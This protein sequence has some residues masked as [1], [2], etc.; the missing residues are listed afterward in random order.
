MIN[1]TNN[2]IRS[3]SASAKKLMGAFLL[4]LLFFGA[5]S[6]EGP[7]IISNYEHA[8]SPA[9]GKLMVEIINLN[10]FKDNE[11]KS[12]YTDGYTLTGMWIRPKLLYYPDEKFRL[13]LGGQVLAYNGRQDYKLYPWFSAV[14]MPTKNIA[15]RMGNLDQDLNHG[16]AEPVMDSEYILKDK[17]EAGFQAKFNFSRWNADF[18]IDWQ[19]MIFKGDPYKERFVFGTAGAVT[20]FQNEKRKL[21]MPIVFNGLHEGGEIDAAPG[22]AQTHIVVS[23]GIKYE[24]ETGGSLIKSGRLECTFLQSTYPQNET[25]LPG[26]S[27]IG[28][29][30][31]T[32][33]NTDYGTFATGYW[34]GNRFFTPLGMPLYQNGATGQ[35]AAVDVNRLLV[36]SYRF[37]HKIFDQSRFG[38]VSDL[39][40]NPSTR[41]ISNCAALYLTVNLSI[42][43]SKKAL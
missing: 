3:T 22:P 18:W 10:F 32:A 4:V 21:S 31:Q 2:L 34:Q 8:D 39:F 9:T 14:Y 30:I 36:F 25:A 38:I 13:E 41:K 23:E 17:P 11:F 5:F 37:D 35:D 27:G 43:C 42:L 20:L 16:L 6:Q 7:R 26:K 1:F 29:F 28:F 19:K 12:K 33:M 15:F 24:Y 40:Y